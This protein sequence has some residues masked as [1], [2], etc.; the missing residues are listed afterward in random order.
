M[1]Q[2]HAALP[3]VDP[4]D[5]VFAVGAARLER[6]GVQCSGICFTG[7][8]GPG[9]MA[10]K[11]LRGQADLLKSPFKSLS[12]RLGQGNHLVYSANIL[13][14]RSVLPAEQVSLSNKKRLACFAGEKGNTD[15]SVL[16]RC[17]P[18]RGD[19]S[20]SGARVFALRSVGRVMAGAMAGSGGTRERC[21]GGRWVSVAG[22]SA[23]AVLG[24]RHQCPLAPSLA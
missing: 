24:Q 15:I 9:V 16:P 17:S 21:G 10:N 22:H 1:W 4:V 20:A 14:A 13:P 23:A 2:P 12:V 6:S 8:R 19:G 18:R 7:T 11:C 3:P 5:E